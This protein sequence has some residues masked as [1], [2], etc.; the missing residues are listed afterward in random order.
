MNLKKIAIVVVIILV[1][2]VG[3]F[4]FISLNTHNTKIEMLSNDTLH[5][6]DVLTVV[7]KDN[8]RNVYPDQDI[9]I[10][11]LDDSG[12]AF[13]YVATTDNDGEASVE[14]LAL[15]P[16]NYTVHSEFNG[17]MFLT[18]SKTTS[19]LQIVDAF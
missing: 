19:N 1:I 14:L 7:L 6:G 18:N 10:K 2:V 4:S 17:T 16:G 15:E 13:K 11:L 12:H 8:Y 5:N 9:N 3:V